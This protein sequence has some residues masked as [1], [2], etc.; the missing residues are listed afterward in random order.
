MKQALFFFGVPTLAMLITHFT[1]INQS[2]DTFN[3]MTTPVLFLGLIIMGVGYFHKSVKKHFILFLGWF[4]FALYWATQP[5][6]LYYKEDGDIVNAVF[7]I[8]GVYFLSYIA[9]HE[10]LSHKR[11]ET[12]RSLQF[13]AGATFFSGMIYFLFQKIDVASG[14][15]IHTVASQTVALLNALGYS[16]EVGG[17][18][19]GIQT[20]APIIFNGHESVQIILAC[21]GLQSMAVFIGVFVALNADVKRRLK[22]FLITVP[23]IYILNLVRNVGIVY[24]V[25]EL[26]LSFYMMH[27]VIG[28][29]GSLLALIAIAFFVFELLPELYDTIMALFKLPKRGGPIERMVKRML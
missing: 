5:E 7:C 20:Y 28:K 23:T 19:H 25:E 27:N 26:N 9:Y 14:W 24:G 17:V 2:V 12:I 8:V 15:L 11:G 22:A 1:I 18:Y 21:T 29:A 10:Y 4:I 6:F 13:L 16:A 3:A